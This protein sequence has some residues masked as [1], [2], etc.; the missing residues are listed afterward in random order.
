MNRAV[1]LALLALITVPAAALDRGPPAQRSGPITVTG[2]GVSTIPVLAVPGGQ[3]LS[4][5][6]TANPFNALTSFALNGITVS[7]TTPEFFHQAN[8]YS[9]KGGTNSGATEYLGSKICGFIGMAAAPGSGPAGA[10]N[11]VLSLGPGPINHHAI[12][13]EADTNN[14]SQHFSDGN[15]TGG[16]GD[17]PI[18]ADI[19]LSGATDSNRYRLSGAI[20]VNGAAGGHALNRGLA[21][22][23]GTVNKNVIEDTMT[24]GGAGYL[25][26]GSKGIGIDM[27][28]MTP[29]TGFAVRL[30]NNAILGAY[31]AAG[32]STLQVLKV[33]PSNIV[34]IAAGSTS[35]FPMSANSA[36]QVRGPISSV[37]GVSLT[38]STSDGATAKPL[39]L[40]GSSVQVTAPLILA[41]SAKLAGLTVSSLPTCNTAAKG[42]MYYVT[43]ATSPTYNGALTGG[44]A[45]AVPA[46][47]NGSAW[48]A[49]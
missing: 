38:S 2:S 5:Q 7:E 11:T 9:T 26:S 34:E 6:P 32:T 4:I 18:A 46:F 36:L 37:D 23:N 27:G 44:G 40:L 20:L 48:T 16:A 43:D 19:Y 24:A 14:V 21:F 13:I 35:S 31:N 8:C 22:Y 41:G 29:T 45:V 42:T 15:L 47:C 17:T 30:P 49:H 12:N 33:N 3:A 28:A 1:F 39:E 10:L 25:M